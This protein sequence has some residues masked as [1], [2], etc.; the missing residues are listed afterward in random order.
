MIDCILCVKVSSATKQ[1]RA[2]RTSSASNLK[3]NISWNSLNVRPGGGFVSSQPSIPRTEER[4]PNIARVPAPC[5]T[6]IS[7]SRSESDSHSVSMDESMSTCDSY[8]SPDV[9]YVDNNEVSLADSVD[10]KTFS[11]LHISESGAKAGNYWEDRI[12]IGQLWI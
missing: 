10:R 7:P 8:K 5:I 12:C 6:A 4:V 2:G 11:S 9:E 3:T 1:S